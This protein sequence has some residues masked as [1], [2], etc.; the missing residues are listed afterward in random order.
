MKKYSIEFKWAFIF[1]FMSLVWMLLER[2]TGLHDENIDQH[3]IYTNL[4]AIPAILIYYFAIK[5]K[6]DRFYKGQISFKQGF[7]SGLIISIM[8]TLITPLSLYISTKFISPEY[9][10]NAVEYSVKNKLMVKNEALAY[11]NY[12]NYLVLSLI[13]AP[14]MGIITSLIISLIIKTRKD[15]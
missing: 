10:T 3:A 12:K 14:V 7:K 13:S 6:R 2:L 11:F 5:E 15:E 8:V 1:I 9:F 4:I